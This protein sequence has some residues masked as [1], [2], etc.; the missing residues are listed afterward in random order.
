MKN[1]IICIVFFAGGS[2]FLAAGFYFLSERYLKSI[3]ENITDPDKK[4]SRR[5]L[6]I[7]AGRFSIF[8]GI[9]TIICGFL[10]VIIPEVKYF[11]ALIYMIVLT[12]AF[13]ILINI[14]K[15]G[16]K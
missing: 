6:G 5:F 4:A 11:I 1:L 15:T 2:V 3:C 8:V 9:L 14:F 10:F 13:F 16:I 7:S 12:A